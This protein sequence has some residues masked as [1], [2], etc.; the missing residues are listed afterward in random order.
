MSAV[1]LLCELGVVECEVELLGQGA[2]GGGAVAKWL[3]EDVMSIPPFQITLCTM[4]YAQPNVMDLPNIT[5]IFRKAK[6]LHR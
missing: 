1:E 4:D 6:K 2:I 5:I 3:V